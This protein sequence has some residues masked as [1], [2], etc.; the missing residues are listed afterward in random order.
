MLDELARPTVVTV[1]DADWVKALEDSTTEKSLLFDGI[2]GRN[3]LMA[4][5]EKEDAIA[6]LSQL[7]HSNGSI[8]L[9]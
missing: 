5:E 9:D 8:V 6:Q 3:A 1:K 7:L 2:V 4:L